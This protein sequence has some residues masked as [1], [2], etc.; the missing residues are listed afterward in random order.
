MLGLWLFAGYQVTQRVRQA[1]RDSAG[2]GTR[3]QQAQELLASVRVAGARGLGAAPRRAARSRRDRSSR[4]SA[5]HRAGV[6][7]DRHAAR[8]SMCPSS[9]RPPSANASIACARRFA[10]SD[11]RPTRCWRPTAAAGRPRRACCC[12]DSC[13]SAKSAIRVSDEVQAL[14]RAAFIDQQR[15]RDRDAGRD[16]ASG[17][18]RLRRGARPSAWS[19]AGSCRGMPRARAAAD[20]T[21]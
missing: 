9:T 20:G 21:A 19:S 1:Q 4:T 5:E 6:R 11:R 7:R 3:Y 13:P 18:D 10:N 16:A 12:A 17:L 8:C 15:E 2:I 14:N